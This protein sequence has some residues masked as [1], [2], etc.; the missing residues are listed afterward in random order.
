MEIFFFIYFTFLNFFF[1]CVTRSGREEIGNFFFLG[2]DT[3]STDNREE[4]KV[5]SEKEEV[6]CSNFDFYYLLE[7]LRI[8]FCALL[9]IM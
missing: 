8:S 1:L 4:H 3:W 2:Q 7:F 6:K 9:S 5:S